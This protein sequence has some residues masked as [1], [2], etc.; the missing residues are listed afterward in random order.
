M[1]IVLYTPNLEIAYEN[2]ILF[3]NYCY[4]GLIN[5]VALINI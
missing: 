3:I 2:S 5:L 4:Q 1:K